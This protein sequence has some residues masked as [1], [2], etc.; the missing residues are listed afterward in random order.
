VDNLP[1]CE[2]DDRA[3]R[4]PWRFGGCWGG[5]LR[6]GDG[7]EFPKRLRKV[8]MVAS[9]VA[10]ALLLGLLASA[11]STGRGAPP[12]QPLQRE[13]DLER[14]MG[15]W[16]VLAH[17]PIDTFFA[18]EA[19]AHNAVETYRL[20]EDGSI[21]TTFTFNEG[22]FDG[23]VKVMRPTGFVHDERTKT[24]WRMQF[25]WP[26]ESAYL[27]V[28]LDEGYERTIIGVPDR[29]YVWIMARTPQI[30]DEEY[31]ELVAEVAGMGHD[32]T[33]LRKV[34]QRQR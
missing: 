27:I 10:A 23:P 20:A 6:Y 34:P 11:C 25:V 1:L 19:D 18:S 29:S 5:F 2:S 7:M 14:F 21:P 3:R 15:A 16:Y 30:P 17:I 12:L 28:Y 9:G 4:C 22:S 8:P 33:K 24:E 13:I 31:D 32:L 26:F